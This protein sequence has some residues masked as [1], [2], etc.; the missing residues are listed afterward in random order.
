ME[1][2]ECKAVM[3]EHINPTCECKGEVTKTEDTF[4]GL[5]VW[6]CSKCG[7]TGISA[8]GEIVPFPVAVLDIKKLIERIVTNS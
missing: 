2:P 7:N 3:H 1:T 6:K 5:P 8:F 4:K